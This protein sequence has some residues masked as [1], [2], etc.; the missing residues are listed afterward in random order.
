MS[1]R[2]SLSH[3]SSRRW[4]GASAL[5]FLLIQFSSTNMSF[6]LAS[7]EEPGDL[8]RE[9]ANT[10]RFMSSS[11][12]ARTV[13]GRESAEEAEELF[14]YSTGA[15]GRRKLATTCI[16][17]SGYTPLPDVDHEGD[18]ITSSGKPALQCTLN[19][20]CLAFNSA[21][22]LKSSITPLVATPGRC[23][24][25]K[26]GNAPSSCANYAGYSVIPDVDHPGDNITFSSTIK[27]S[28]RCSSDPLCKGF[29]SDG[30]TKSA[31]T[32]TVP[33]KGVCFYTKIV[34]SPPPPAQDTSTAGCNDAAA[35]LA[36]HNKDRALHGCPALT[37][38]ETLAKGAQ[39][40]AQ[41]L[42]ANCTLTSVAGK[43]GENLY[44]LP[45]DW[46][47]TAPEASCAKAVKFWYSGV[48]SY[49]FTSTPWSDNALNFGSIGLFTQ[50]VWKST[51]Q[52]GC[53]AALSNDN[54]CFVVSCRYLP[55]GNYIGNSQFF[56]NVLPLLRQGS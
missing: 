41:R 46:P 38:N 49:K 19:R 36:E 12:S 48:S 2:R 37:W 10:R 20:A 15:I 1:S 13:I 18:T 56:N 8:L 45:S 14:V 54:M 6:A 39:A 26:Q 32:P 9:S 35:A 25:V 23:L 16:K 44:A 47:L 7:D 33:A 4:L 24:Y 22:E 43:Y 11:L 40:W 31:V 51:T 34:P 30:W 42:A 50:V 3:L 52:V 5:L 27:P 21:G 53:G 28:D 17:V 55:P 29:N